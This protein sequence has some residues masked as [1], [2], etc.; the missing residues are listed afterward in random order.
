MPRYYRRR[1]R[2]YRRRRGG[3]RPSSAQGWSA[4][5]AMGMAS[6][7][8]SIAMGVKALLNVEKKYFDTTMTGTVD[9]TGTIQSVDLIPSQ[10]GAVDQGQSRDG[11]Q[12]RTKAAYWTG[13]VT[14]HASA[15]T[16]LFRMLLVLDKQPRG[17]APG[18]TDVLESVS[19][20]ALRNMVY[21]NR[22][23]VLHDRTLTLDADN[24]QRVFKIFKR[25]SLKQQY[26]GDSTDQP[27]NASLFV[28]FFSNEATNTPTL[29]S[30]FR[31]RFIDN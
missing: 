12:V 10:E 3:R 21:R 29:Q 25:M 2:G 31:I 20:V 6:R 30:Q 9:N 17:D 13:N 27:I 4:S 26:A 8:L 5:G 22:F 16:T 18:V 28:I 11:D 1:R 23:V 19:T 7:A 15:T 14:K 24:P